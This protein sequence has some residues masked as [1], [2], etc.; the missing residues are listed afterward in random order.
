MDWPRRPLR[1]LAAMLCLLALAGGT[2]LAK[3][4]AQSFTTGQFMVACTSTGQVCSPPESLTFTLAHR[5]VL[6]SVTYTTSHLHC[7]AVRLRVLLHGNVVAKTHKLVAGDRTDTVATHVTLPQGQTTLGFQAQGYKG[8]CN[9]GQLGS[10]G[11][12]VTVT[13]ARAARRRH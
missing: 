9:V 11:G 5:G 1:I 7:S 13:V 12:K 3:T 8:G 10:W 6:K 2:A 4:K